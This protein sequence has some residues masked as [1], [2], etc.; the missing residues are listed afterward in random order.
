MRRRSVAHWLRFASGERGAL[1][2]I[3]GLL[4]GTALILYGIQQAPRGTSLFT[5][6]TATRVM[7]GPWDAPAGAAGERAAL[8]A[9]LRRGLERQGTLAVVDSAR[10]ARRLLE[11]GPGAAPGSEGFRRAVQA[12]NP[13]LAIWGQVESDGERWRGRL[14]ALDV[15]AGVISFACDAS[16]PNGAAV[17]AA[18]ADSVRARLF[19]PRNEPQP[20]PRTDREP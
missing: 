15:H 2:W 17:G 12:L 18:L 4:A 11:A 19:T 3:P 10:V 5:R 8:L 16:G 1:L 13:H 20:G 6:T 14:E 9:A 7:L